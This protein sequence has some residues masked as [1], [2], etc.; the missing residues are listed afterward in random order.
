[1]ETTIRIIIAVLV[2]AGF[3]LFWYCENRRKNWVLSLK[4]GMA[5]QYKNNIHTIK[6]IHWGDEIC[7][8]HGVPGY[9]RLDELK[10]VKVGRS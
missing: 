5:V 1:M 7:T 8:L 9:V 6:S 4:D 2:V 10:R 3:V